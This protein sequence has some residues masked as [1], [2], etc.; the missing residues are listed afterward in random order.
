MHQNEV[1]DD[2]KQA[3]VT[4]I[5][6]KCN[7]LEVHVPNISVQQDSGAHN[8][9]LANETPG[10]IP[11]IVPPTAWPQEKAFMR[12]PTDLYHIRPILIIGRKYTSIRRTIYHIHGQALTGAR[13]GKSLQPYLKCS[14]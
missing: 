2:W 13:T 4:P 9:Q 1:P 11:D 7:Q 8:T 12:E 10:H 5:F 3:N 6:K 14:T